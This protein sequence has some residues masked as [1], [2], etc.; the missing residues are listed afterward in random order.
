[1]NELSIVSPSYKRA[2][3]VNSIAIFGEDL[4]L[5]VHEFE[6]ESYRQA[7]PDNPILVL[8][9]ETRKNMGK[10]RNYIKDHCDARYLLM[11]DDDIRKISYY[12]GREK[13]PKPVKKI[14][15]LIRVGFQ[16]AEDLGTVLW[17]INIQTDPKF[18]R[19]NAPFSMLSAVLGPFCGHLCT[20]S[21][22]RYDERLGLNEDYD[23]FLQV[24][25]KYHKV[26]RL[27]KYHYFAGHLTDK[28]GCGAYRMLAEEKKQAAIMQQKWGHKIV[29]YNFKRSTNPQIHVPLKGI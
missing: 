7:Y 24:I 12:E 29:K 17:G 6:A 1:M 22:L 13:T 9:D 18:Y 2:G 25:Q 21:S 14:E 8:P 26:L 5:A 27:N 15:E 10:V 23:Y 16:M 4:C 3:N 20:D 28:G 19:Q 11:V